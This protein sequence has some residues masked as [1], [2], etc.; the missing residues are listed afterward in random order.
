MYQITQIGNTVYIPR[1]N[2]SR[3]SP[4]FRSLS[5]DDIGPS[6]ACFGDMFRVTHKVHVED[7]MSMEFLHNMFGR[8]TD[9]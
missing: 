5:T 6:S 1:R 9:S 3:V 2:L 4:S 8:D 7:T